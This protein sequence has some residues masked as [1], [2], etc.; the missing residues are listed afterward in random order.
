MEHYAR[1]RRVWAYAEDSLSLR[2]RF[3]PPLEV[4]MLAAPEDVDMRDHPRYWH[5]LGILQ[6]VV[7]RTVNAYRAAGRRAASDEEVNRALRQAHVEATRTKT[8]E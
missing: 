8:E 6:Y 3:S 1:C 7:L 4:W 5:H 2:C